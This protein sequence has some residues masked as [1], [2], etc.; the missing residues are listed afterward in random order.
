MT[1]TGWAHSL[2]PPA[3]ATDGWQS[4]YR[5]TLSITATKSSPVSG[6]GLSPGMPSLDYE[7][8]LNESV[9]ML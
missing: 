7:I 5:R 1:A 9:V 3:Q 6:P 4:S 2:M 8:Q